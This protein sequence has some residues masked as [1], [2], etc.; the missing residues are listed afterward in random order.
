[1]PSSKITIKEIAS[2]LGLSIATVSR[3][4]N[5]SYDIH[6][7]TKE[8]VLAKA[9]ELHYKPN[10]QA[11]NLLKRRNN[12]IGVVVP[13]FITFFFPEIIIGIQEV[14]NKHGYQVLICQSNE[15]SSLERKNVEMLEDSMVEGLIVSVTKDSKNMDL[16]ERLVQDRMPMVFVN[17][18]LPQLNVNQVVIDDRKWAFQTVEHLI[19]CGYKC[20]AHLA[21]NPD[22]SV[23]KERLHGYLDALAAYGIPVQEQLIMYVGIQQERAKD[24][25]DYLMV[26]KERPD[27]IFA[28]NDPVAVGCMLEL[29]KRGLR[30]P[31]DVAVAGFSESP[32]GKIMELTSVSQPTFEIGKIAAEMLLKQIANNDL[33]VETVVLEAKLNIR[34]STLPLNKR[35]H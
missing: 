25:I 35:A 13:E 28:V 29:R 1:M 33:P 17:R 19:K 2:A 8:K 18:V 9:R 27:A 23:T 16:Y 5:G 26:L 14:V 15:S 24:G 21:G 20:I 3:A 7:E 10:I 32:I 30:I 34:N 31:E 4:L 22:L 11:R 12:M 6:L